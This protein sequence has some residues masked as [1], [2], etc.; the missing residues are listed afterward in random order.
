[1]KANRSTRKID[2]DWQRDGGRTPLRGV[3][4]AGSGERR[5]RTTPRRMKPPTDLH[6]A[7]TYVSQSSLRAEQTSVNINKFPQALD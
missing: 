7:G 1:M 6:V 4:G 3:V 2:R 5:H